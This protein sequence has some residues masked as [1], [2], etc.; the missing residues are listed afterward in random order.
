[1]GGCKGQQHQY[2]HRKTIGYKLGNCT[3]YSYVI[4]SFATFSGSSN[5]LVT[6][7]TL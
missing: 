4:S 2:G 6:T 3:S 7:K 1:M 5:S